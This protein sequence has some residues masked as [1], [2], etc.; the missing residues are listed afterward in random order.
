[1]V[2]GMIRVAYRM[3]IPPTQT[4]QLFAVRAVF[5]YYDFTVPTPPVSG[6]SRC[7]YVPGA[8]HCWQRWMVSNAACLFPMPL[9]RHWRLTPSIVHCLEPDYC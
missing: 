2:H 6:Q 1:M 3:Q 7:C 8:Q 4:Q 9:Q 5:N